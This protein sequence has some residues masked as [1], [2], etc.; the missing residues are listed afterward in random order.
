MLH[1]NPLLNN[2]VLISSLAF[3]KNNWVS[4][5]DKDDKTNGGHK[6]MKTEAAF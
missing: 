1:S 4:F 2:V 6:H 5:K 3:Q